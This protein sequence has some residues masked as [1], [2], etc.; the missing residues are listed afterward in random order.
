MAVAFVF[1]ERRLSLA[2]CDTDLYLTPIKL[3]RP[4]SIPAI[5]DGGM[6]YSYATENMQFNYSMQLLQEAERFCLNEYEMVHMPS[7]K[8]RLKSSHDENIVHETPDNINTAFHDTSGY[9]T[10]LDVMQ[11]P[12]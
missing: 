5:E 12:I 8:N 2:E 6:S 9:L 1:V 10:V 3:E 7:I 4:P 11:T